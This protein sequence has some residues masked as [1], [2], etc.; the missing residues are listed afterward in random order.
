MRFLESRF[1]AALFVAGLIVLGYAAVDQTGFRQWAVVLY[2][3][4]VLA[5][6]RIT[7]RSHPGETGGADRGSM[8]LYGLSRAAVVV[9]AV[10]V[11]ASW[12]PPMVPWLIAALAGMLAG[13][14]IRLTAIVQLGRFYSHKVRTLPGHQVVQTG[15]Y[16]LVRHPAYLGMIV[17]HVGFVACFANP[18]SIAALILLVV[19][20]V[21]RVLVEEQTLMHVSGY[22][23]YAAG[24]ARLLPA[25]W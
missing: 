8:Q 24:H 25:V 22:S 17:A 10:L 15:L 13:I 16:G 20:I 11:P 21:R 1:P 19:A 14:A 12:S 4:W 2:L 3:L 23:C 7:F 5:E 6:L 9:T 18:A